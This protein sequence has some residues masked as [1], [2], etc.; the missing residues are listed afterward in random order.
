MMKTSVKTDVLIIGGGGAGFRAAIGAREKGANALLLSKG[1]LARCGATPMAGADFTLDGLSLSKMGFPGESKDTRDKFL[2]DMLTNGFFLNNQKLCD[3]YIENAPDRLQELLDWGWK[4]IGSEER[5]V[6]GSGIGIMDALLK[7]AKRVGVSFMEDIFVLDLTVQDGR[8]T[9]AVGLDVKTGEFIIFESKSV[10]IATGGWHK[11]F[12]PNTGMRDLSGDGIAMAHRAGADIG[13]ME[14]ITFCANVLYEPPHCRG[15]LATYLFHY[16]FG[17]SLNNSRGEPFLEKFDPLVQKMGTSTEWNKCFISFASA[18]EAKAGKTGPLGGVFYGLG[19]VPFSEFEEKA[20]Q[21]MPNWKYKALDLSG[22]AARFKAGE[23]VEVGPAVEYFDG[24]IVVNEQF[25]TDVAGLF[26]AG[27]CV[28]GPF[29]ANRVFA[30]I[31][32]MLVHGADAGQ[33]AADYALSAQ[34]AKAENVA[35]K[36]MME[37]ALTPLERGGDESPAQ[38]RRRIQE[39]A[40]ADLSPVRTGS[41]LSA[42]IDFLEGIKQTELPNLGVSSKSRVY[43]KGWFDVLELK[44]MVHLL[45]A[46]ARSALA[47]TESRGVH[48]REDFPDTDNEGWLQESIVRLVN[49]QMDINHRPVTVTKTA[50]PTGVQSYQETLKQMM[51]AH[52]DIGGGH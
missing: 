14:F 11:A 44:N 1:P 46:A 47:R 41:E 35:L 19:D 6:Y 45:E 16:L 51:A 29:G 26:A 43:N 10:V 25:E 37:A 9:G 49:G 15:S 3:Q 31:T 8:V 7:Q 50:L 24:G 36:A 23:T 4:I 34:G 42:F 52:S 28:L 32:E 2:N 38:L 39:R 40:H 30:A 5:A 33:N 12:W 17:G 18:L 27:E 22:I 13:N 48:F 21:W 20:S